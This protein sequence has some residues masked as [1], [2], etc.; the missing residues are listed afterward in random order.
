MSADPR[1]IVEVLLES[2]PV[3]SQ[4]DLER[5]L[6]LV[7][8]HDLA[9]PLSPKQIRWIAR[10]GKQWTLVEF[11]VSN[12]YDS[13]PGADPGAPLDQPIVIA[14]VDGEVKILDGQHRYSKANREGVKTLPAYVPVEH[15][16]FLNESDD[17]DL[18]AEIDRLPVEYEYWDLHI[19]DPDDDN[20]DGR[21]GAYFVYVRV[22][23]FSDAEVG[24]EISDWNDPIFRTVVRG[25]FRANYINHDETEN[26]LAV[27]KVP[28]EEVGEQ[29]G[30]SRIE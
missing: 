23:V 21:T 26:V 1:Q 19:N 2:G 4:Q 13:A 29:L 8:A 24:V 9:G 28:E 22:P 5:W 20:E 17:F 11:P 30:A 12:W 7:N 27:T 6:T 18:Q 10:H 14:V 3:L 16:P 15:V 25:A